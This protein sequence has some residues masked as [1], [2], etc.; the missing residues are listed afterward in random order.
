MGFG[1]EWGSTRICHRPC[2][3][4]HMIY[5]NDLPEEVCGKVC[6]FADDTI[7]YVTMTGERDAASLQQDLDH[8][9]DWKEKWQMKFH[10]QKCSVLRITRTKS[11]KIFNY[12][13]HG[14]TL[15]S[16]TDS[17]YLRVTINNKLSWNNHIDNICNKANSSIAFLRRNLQISQH[18]IKTNAYFTLVR[19][20]VE[21]A[22]MVCDPYTKENI[23]KTEMVQRRAARYVCK[24]YA[25]ED[26]CVTNILQQLG[27]CSLLQRRVDIRLVFLYK[28]VHGLVAVDISDDLI[29]KTRPSCH[30]NSMSYNIPVETKTYIQK[31]FLPRT[32]TQWNHLPESV[33]TSSSLDTFKEGVSGI[34]H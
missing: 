9:A 24:N 19:P 11:T 25:R 8:L 15:K 7:M 4:S 14:H 26:G 22:A 2:S 6:L 23:Q 18:H 16:E 5:N 34:T 33:V 3:L 13:L 32:I 30:C 21:Y 17:K 27:W 10:P 1:P 28:C 31:S 12:Q 20:Q 29:T